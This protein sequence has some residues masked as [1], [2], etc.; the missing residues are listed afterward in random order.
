MAS[1]ATILSSFHR[2]DMAA[3]FSGGDASRCQ[4]TT[5][6]VVGK[7][8]NP[9]PQWLDSTPNKINKILTQEDP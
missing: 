3:P 7:H 5:D 2:A 8:D 9:T 6:P 1:T 4:E